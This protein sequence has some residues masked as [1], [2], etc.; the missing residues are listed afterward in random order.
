MAVQ[1]GYLGIS[2]PGD[3]LRAKRSITM[4]LQGEVRTL[5]YFGLKYATWTNS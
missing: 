3:S 2:H 4:C 1:V 5:G